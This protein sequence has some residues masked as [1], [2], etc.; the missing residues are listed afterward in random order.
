MC[1]VGVGILEREEGEAETGP[2]VS[3]GA[4]A[5]CSP[6]LAA[7]GNVAGGMICDRS[8]DVEDA[9]CSRKDTGRRDLVEGGSPRIPIPFWL[10]P[11]PATDGVVRPS[12]RAVSQASRSPDLY[13]QSAGQMRDPSGMPGSITSANPLLHGMSVLVLII[14]FAIE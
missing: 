10:P 9:R 14:W 7:V 3:G 1:D 12:F 2:S 6:E 11:S 5:S 4:V 8:D 13:V